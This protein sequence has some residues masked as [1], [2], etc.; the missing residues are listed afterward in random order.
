M[1]RT[2]NPFLERSYRR[3]VSRLNIPGFRRGKAPRRIVESMVGRTA[4]LQEALDFMVP[5]TLDRVL[6]D[7]SVAAFGEPDIEVTDLEPVSFKATVPLEP[8]ID[9]GDYLALRVEPTPLEV[10]DEEVEAL[11]DRL[12]DEQAVWEPVD[13]PAEY[14]D[15][16]NIDVHGEI[17]SETV[18]EDEDIEYV[19][20]EDNVL[21]FPG[22]A[23][24][25]VGM[26][27]DEEREFTV[28]IPED[29]PREQFAGKDVAFKVTVLSVKQKD[30]PEL[31]DDFAMSLGEDY[32]DLDSLRSGVRESML[33]Q[34]EV[35]NRND[36][37]QKSLEALRESAIVNASP[38]LY[39]RELELMQSEREQRLQQQGL[40]L[41]TYLRFHG[42]NRRGIPGRNAPRCRASPGTRP[43]AAQT[44]RG[45]RDRRNRRRSP[46]RNR[47]PD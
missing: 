13:R 45:G 46:G 38:L 7:E 27:E 16:L 15:R 31:D 37:E 14:G 18:V 21:P 3:T 40:D 25:L 29:Y 32:E 28:T 42:P 36:L 20:Q 2:R 22:F 34:A 4:L 12:R 33:A 24:H 9:L 11:L 44:G 8:V 43:G 39:Q 1:P 23:P 6:A 47:T 5:E 41:A 19:P 26:V 35:A 17:D 30:L 10:N